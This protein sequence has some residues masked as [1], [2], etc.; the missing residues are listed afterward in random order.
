MHVTPT[1]RVHEFRPKVTAK[2]VLVGGQSGAPASP[3][4]FDQATRYAQGT[5]RDIHFY[6][7]DIAK[8]ATETYRPGRSTR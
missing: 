6:P 1:G 4:F 5:L 8:H 3:H 7:E 2:A